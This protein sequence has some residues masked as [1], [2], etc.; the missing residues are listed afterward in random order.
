MNIPATEATARLR[1]VAIVSILTDL[2]V[3]V[4]ALFLLARNVSGP[5]GSGWVGVIGILCIIILFMPSVLVSMA[6]PPKSC[7][8]TV[9]IA[10]FVMLLLLVAF[11]WEETIK[12][13][14][15]GIVIATLAVG[16]AYAGKCIYVAWRVDRS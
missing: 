5:N 6:S 9:L 3:G 15:F 16:F 4:P 7:R 2:F 13:V 10:A 8:R 1:P 11:A 12:A 14:E